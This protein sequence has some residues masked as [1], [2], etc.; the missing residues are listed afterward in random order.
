V[1]RSDFLKIGLLFIV[2]GMCGLVYEVVW[3]R[4]LSL[5]IGSTVFAVSIVISAFLGGLVVGSLVFGRQADKTKRPLIFYAGLEVAV[6]LLALGLTLVLKNLPAITA[7]CGLPG[8]G[9]QWLRVVL[10]FVLIV[11]PTAAMGGTLP[12]I[13]RFVVS[14]LPKVGKH[15]GILYSLNTLGAAIGTYLAGFFLIAH[16]G[17]FMTAL[18]TA[19]LNFVVA[20]AAVVLHFVVKPAR[21]EKEEAAPAPEPAEPAGALDYSPIAGRRRQLLIVA[22]ALAG[23]SSISYEV[24]WFRLLSLFMVSNTYTFTILLVT[25]L[26]GLVIGGLIYVVWLSKK[27]KDLELFAG[28]QLLLAFL[29]LLSAG[30]IGFSPIIKFYSGEIFGF[31]FRN[32]GLF[33]HA[34]LVILIPATVIGIV[35][36]LVVQLTTTHLKVTGKNVGITYSVNTIGGIIGS[37]MMGFILIPMIG[38]Q[39]SFYLIA[40]LNAA[41][42]ILV[43]SVDQQA[44]KRRR[45]LVYCGA[46]LIVPTI[47]MFPADYLKNAYSETPFGEVLEVVED[48]DG[49]LAVIEYSS[50]VTCRNFDC[51]KR[52]SKFPF[53]HRKIFFGSVSYSSTILTSQRY[54]SSL[55]HIPM[56]IHKDPKKVLTVCLGT[57]ITAGTFTLYDELEALTVVDLNKDVVDVAA[58]YFDKE[59]RRVVSNNKTKIV[60]AD[61]RNFLLTTQE[62]F[63]VIS[64]E[65]PPPT[66]PGTVNLYTREFYELIADHLT[67]DGLLTQ[68]IPMQHQSDWL[69]RMLIRS[70]QDVFEHV[71]IWM[72]A[73]EEAVILASKKPLL[74][75]L[76]R[77]QERWARPQL[78]QAL[79]AV[80][81]QDAYDLLG[82]F[83][84]GA[85]DLAGY[86]K[87]YDPITDDLPAVEYYLSRFDRPFDRNEF[88]GLASNPASLLTGGPLDLERL[89]HEQ[90]VTGMMLQASLS[91]RQKD[92]PG[93]KKIVQKA[94]GLGE[95][96]VYIQHLDNQL[97][98]CMVSFEAK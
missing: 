7:A 19:I 9:P 44:P 97:Y 71:S 85:E 5:T 91:A 66:T 37:L 33:L 69:N 23:F 42:A 30:L 22:F 24:L 56:M 18:L 25:F 53:R 74:I 55:A 70:M 75:D 26:L 4:Y 94:I 72:P 95:S 88:I 87:K 21:P 67:S 51:P 16:L 98:D 92:Y 31:G 77:M 48:R 6:G 64:F 36:P 34:A 29:G 10:T 50:E 62:K 11:P 47:L 68:W 46:F 93:A 82:V 14:E 15:F 90:R 27:N 17:L 73:R 86:T 65:P 49:N 54:M 59:N 35:F 39:K 96:D 45:W 38:T 78:A 80:G 61:G 20:G 60:V 58:K 1:R 63:D 28:A 40:G 79:E 12:M 84:V 3:L 52:C 8:G 76:T 57:G 2:S 13:T 32:I 43:L 83:M 89:E 81:Y 41:I